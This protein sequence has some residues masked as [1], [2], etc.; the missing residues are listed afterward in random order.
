MVKLDNVFL[1]HW[2][3]VLASTNSPLTGGKIRKLMNRKI[4]WDYQAVKDAIG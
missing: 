2:A 1:Q 3:D 4:G